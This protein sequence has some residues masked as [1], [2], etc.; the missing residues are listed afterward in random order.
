MACLWQYPELDHYINSKFE[1]HVGSFLTLFFQAC[2]CA[3]S[4]NFEILKPAL[5]Q[6]KEKYPI[7]RKDEGY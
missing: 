5:I 2:H 1:E 3:D 4:E 6:L 7:R